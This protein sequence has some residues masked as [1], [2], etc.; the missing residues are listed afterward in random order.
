MKHDGKLGCK[1]L[2]NDENEPLSTRSDKFE[3][4][5]ATPSELSRVLNLSD[6]GHFLVT[7]CRG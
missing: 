1:I 7:D 2:P 4:G 5:T 3:L 6:L